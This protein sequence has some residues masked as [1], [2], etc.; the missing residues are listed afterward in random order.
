MTQREPDFATGD[1]VPDLAELANL[2]SYLRSFP[3]IKDVEK[4]V[5]WPRQSPD[6]V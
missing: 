4:P 6:M 3:L 5:P 2:D 1:G